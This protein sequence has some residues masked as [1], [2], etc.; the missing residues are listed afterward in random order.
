VVCFVPFIFVK[1]SCIQRTSGS[2]SLISETTSSLIVAEDIWFTSL[3]RCAL[4]L[5]TRIVE[6]VLASSCDGERKPICCVSRGQ[7]KRIGIKVY[8]VYRGRRNNQYIRKP[9]LTTKMGR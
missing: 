7:P 1:N 5:M 4:K 8:S 6:S 2:V 3:K 9:I